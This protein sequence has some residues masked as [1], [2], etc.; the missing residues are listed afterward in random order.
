MSELYVHKQI[1]LTVDR[2]SGSSLGRQLLQQYCRQGGCGES[3]ALGR[4]VCAL[5]PKVAGVNMAAL[6]SG[7]FREVPRIPFAVSE[8]LVCVVCVRER[9][10]GADREVCCLSQCHLAL[11]YTQYKRRHTNQEISR[12]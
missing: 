1:T 7:Y 4:V 9:K 8:P 10:R 6:V 2:V 12:M 11:T 5:L 3:S